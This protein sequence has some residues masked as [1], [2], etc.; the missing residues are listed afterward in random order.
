MLTTGSKLYLG[1]AALA[2]AALGVLGWATGWE[3]Q[4]TVGAGSVLVVFLFLAGLML[5]V[6]DANVFGAPAPMRS[7]RLLLGRG[8]GTGR[9]LRRR[10]GGHRAGPGHPPV[11]RRD[12]RRG[13]GRPGVG[14][15]V[16]G[17]PGQRRPRVQRPRPRP[18][19]APPRVP[20]CRAC[21]AV[22]LI[23]FGFSRVMV[24]LSRK[25]GSSPSPSSA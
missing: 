11:H 10:S 23:V 2:A 8:V 3:M 6:R 14:G 18:A 9:R 24:A 13:P 21:S 1:L 7:P 15:P 16:L 4:A 20:R 22:G 17:R 12:G 25:A 19:D 5:Y